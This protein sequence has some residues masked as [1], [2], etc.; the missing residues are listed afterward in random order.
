MS[1]MLSQDNTQF[2]LNTQNTS[3]IMAVYK[4]YLLHYYYGSRID[5]AD[6]DYMR[7]HTGRASFSTLN[8][9]EEPAFSLDTA[10]LEYPCCC[11]LYTSRCV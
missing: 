6:C 4:G 1:I 3:Y 8:D 5:G 9:P 11:L 7:Y 2:Q 10:L